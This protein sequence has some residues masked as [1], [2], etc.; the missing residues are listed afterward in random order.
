MLEW[1]TESIDVSK[2]CIL[3]RYK[4]T[5]T[6]IEKVLKEV[7]YAHHGCII[8][9]IQNNCFLFSYVSKCNVFLWWAEWYLSVDFDGGDVCSLV[10]I[11]D[12]GIVSISIGQFDTDATLVG[13][14]MGIGHYQAITTYDEAGAIRDRHLTARK[15]V[16]IKNKEYKKNQSTR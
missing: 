1:E 12:C 7:Y 14:H 13:N 6:T 15:R 11:L 16:S 5:H 3:S 8:I 4:H 2:N 9:T 10:Y